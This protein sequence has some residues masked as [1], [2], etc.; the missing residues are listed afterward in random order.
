MCTILDSKELEAK[1]YSDQTGKFPIRSAS[2]NQYLFVLYHYDTNIIHAV[3]IK[4]RHAEHICSAWKE[5]FATL[6]HHGEQPNL[7]IL[8]NECLYEF[9]K[10]SHQKK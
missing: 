8:D 3:L 5:C 2:G 4:S 7:H 1:S 10:S 6:K 9:K